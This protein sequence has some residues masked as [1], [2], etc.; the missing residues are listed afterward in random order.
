MDPF[1]S[2]ASPFPAVTMTDVLTILQVLYIA[3]VPPLHHY[4]QLLIN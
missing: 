3:G 2:M 1:Q 4:K